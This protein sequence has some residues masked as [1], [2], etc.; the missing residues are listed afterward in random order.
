MWECCV[1]EGWGCVG[2]AGVGVW[3]AK[4]PL[5]STPF[6][7]R[8]PHT[9]S[10]NTNVSASPFYKHT[11]PPSTTGPDGRAGPEAADAEGPRGGGPGLVQHPAQ[12]P[13]HLREVGRGAQFLAG[14]W[15]G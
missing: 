5:P 3:N 4:R 13:G 11:T 15:G 10:T 14:G 2:R 1:F 9:P 7:Y 12:R 6:P 8:P